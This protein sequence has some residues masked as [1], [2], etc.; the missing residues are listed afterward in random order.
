[1]C[2]G[3]VKIGIVDGDEGCGTH[4]E[5]RSFESEEVACNAWESQEDVEKSHHLKIFHGEKRGN[6]KG[7]HFG[8]GNSGD[9]KRRVA[10]KECANELCPIQIAAY[11]AY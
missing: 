11:F 6:G 5:D 3:K 10:L 8:A 2:E 4:L 7:A 1:L 9:L